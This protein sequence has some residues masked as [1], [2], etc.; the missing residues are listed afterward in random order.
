MNKKMEKMEVK[1]RRKTLIISCFLVLSVLGLSFLVGTRWGSEATWVSL[2]YAFLV[3]L[4]LGAQI[5]GF[6]VSQVKYSQ[7]IEAV[8][9]EVLK[10]EGIEWGQK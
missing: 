10:A 1:E 3:T 8:K 2:I 9:Y 6:V 7:S 4:F 5:W